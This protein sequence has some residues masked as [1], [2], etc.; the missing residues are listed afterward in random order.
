VA[1]FFGGWSLP[2]GNEALMNMQLMKD[3]PVLLG[4]VFGT[5]FWVK[6]LLIVYLQMVIR[7]T[8][9]RFRY[10]QIQKLGWQILLPMGLVNLFVSGALILWDPSLRALALFGFVVLGTVAF[11]TLTPPRQVR[12]QEEEAADH[13]GH[14]HGGHGGHGGHDDHAG[15]GHDAAHDHAALPANTH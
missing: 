7:W 12:R 10:D 15:H 2:F 11:L 6:V 8:M 13:G 4:A 14:G 9:P 5:V 3:H 1:I